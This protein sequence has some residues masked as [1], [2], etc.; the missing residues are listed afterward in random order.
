MEIENKGSLIISC[1]CYGVSFFV[2]LAILFWG[3][4]GQI[5]GGEMDYVFITMF[6][7]MPI[8]SLISALILGLKKTF[9]KWIYP[10]LFGAF[11]Y[12]IPLILFRTSGIIY[13]APTLLLSLMGLVIG[14][15][16][17]K[18]RI[19]YTKSSKGFTL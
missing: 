14:V 2:I 10:F 8:T 13:V 7:I 15:A 12:I 1:V 16:L 4:F 9:L 3:L 18:K 5:T 17:R 11:I 6:L 19:N